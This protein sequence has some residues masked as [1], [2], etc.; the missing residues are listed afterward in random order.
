M[1][2]RNEKQSQN[3]VEE[4]TKKIK[5]SL[6]SALKVVR[7]NK[8]VKLEHFQEFI[9]QYGIDGFQELQNPSQP[10]W[11]KGKQSKIPISL[12]TQRGEVEYLVYST[13]KG[14]REA[15]RIIV[16]DLL[17]G[18]HI[19]LGKLYFLSNFLLKQRKYSKLAGTIAN[20]LYLYNRMLA[21][22]VA[23][24]DLYYLVSEEKYGRFLPELK[25][26][27]KS[28]ENYREILKYFT[29]E[30]DDFLFNKEEAKNIDYDNLR[31]VNEVRQIRKPHLP[32]RKRGYDDKGHLPD[33][34]KSSVDLGESSAISDH[35]DFWSEY[36]T[37][38]R[39][40]F[41]EFITKLHKTEKPKEKK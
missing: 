2:K 37:K 41:N 18:G 19:N 6:D 36:L 25:R 21:T 20:L 40:Q 9:S 16:H 32:Q 14:E 13:P 4:L 33:P 30:L 34:S 8:P 15:V 27:F 7:K 22:K 1:S 29:E 10:C 23:D 11:S 26:L 39:P 17:I 3:N 28:R 5:T 24:D 12:P 31:F 38:V 35:Y